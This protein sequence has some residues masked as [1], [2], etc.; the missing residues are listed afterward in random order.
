MC[1]KELGYSWIHIKN[2]TQDVQVY[3]Y[4]FCYKVEF[5]MLGWYL[6]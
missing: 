2:S 3:D 1:D 4:W 6:C 5:G